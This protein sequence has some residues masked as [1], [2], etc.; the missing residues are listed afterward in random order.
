MT[1]LSSIGYT[2]VAREDYHCHLLT[3][4][5]IHVPTKWS[6]WALTTLSLC[7]SRLYLSSDKNF[8]L[9]R[10]CSPSHEWPFNLLVSRAQ[11]SSSVAMTFGSSAYLRRGTVTSVADRKR[12]EIHIHVLK[13]ITDQRESRTSHKS[14]SLPNGEIPKRVI[15]ITFGIETREEEAACRREWQ[16]PPTCETHRSL[17]AKISSR[18][19]GFVESPLTS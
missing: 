3:R 8:V 15:S 5:K 11:R 13:G 1:C 9:G 14:R 4:L 12:Y 6:K 17:L 18:S 16:R 19:V 2:S 10:S 7:S